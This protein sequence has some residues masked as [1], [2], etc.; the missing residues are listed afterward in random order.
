MTPASPPL[1][2]LVIGAGFGG[3]GLSVQLQR[4]GVTDYLVLEKAD[5]VGG[6]WRD[7]TYPGAA[8][9]VPSHLYSFSFA[10]RPQW[11]RK[12]APQG[13]IFAYLRDVAERF[14]LRRNIR[15][16]REVAE[17]RFDEAAGQWE[18]RT[19]GGEVYRARALVSACGQLNRPAYPRVPGLE[20]F[21]G[22]A[23]HSARWRH[24]V[25]LA[26]KRVGVIGTGASAI[27]LVPEVAKEAARL[28]VFQRSA[29][30]VIAKAD[31]P[32]RRWELAA[33]ARVP[34][35]LRLSRLWTYLRHEVRVVA[36]AFLPVLMRAYAWSFGRHLAR[37]VPDAAL[38]TRVTPDYPMG[39]KR[40]LISNDWYAALAR[41]NVE[42]VDAGLREV[43][44]R[45]VVTADGVE[46]ELDVLIYGT[47]FTA[48]DFLA[49][50]RVVG[51]GG[52]ELNAAWRE[53]AEAYLGVAVSGFP[54][55]FLLYGPN[56]NLG[57]NSIVYM[58]ESQFRYVLSGLRLLQRGARF[59][60]VREAPQ[61]G[62]NAWVQRALGRSVWGG[63]CTSWY[64][65]AEGKN[66]NNWPGFTFDYRLR[67][68][69]VRAAD[70]DIVPG[71]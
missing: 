15:F 54:N 48:T 29:P 69:A 35:L 34:G 28:H 64:K 56:T 49:P 33:L 18:V 13:E 11:S 38:R 50:M 37:Q 27:Q 20:R 26:G 3:L 65:T 43:T 22:V 70:H 52:R 10:P 58:L 14:D 32:Y 17:A 59:L 19:T 12:Y 45:G 2:V 41:P 8:C 71:P 21:G 5:D 66:T 16:G 24:D 39:C 7:N 47:G 63:G 31:R 68:R 23:F 62:F 57:H 1:Q 55:L 4:A 30:Y 51:R 61:R 40:V 25:P 36:F 6:C 9:D 67:T 46:R 44:E 42:V 53:G 60:D